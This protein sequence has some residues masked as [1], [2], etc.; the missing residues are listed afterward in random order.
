MPLSEGAHIRSR[1]SGG[2]FGPAIAS[3][4]DWRD[5]CCSRR[6][7]REAQVLRGQL[8]E[9]VGIELAATGY[10]ISASE[11]LPRIWEVRAVK[12][13]ARAHTLIATRVSGRATNASYFHRHLALSYF[14][15][16]IRLKAT[17]RNHDARYETQA[18]SG[19]GRSA[20]ARSRRSCDKSYMI[21]KLHCSTSD[22]M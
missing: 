11:A 4:G 17:K 12:G 2:G 9:L 13:R 14:D 10:V 1:T 5:C 19:V 16:T 7:W 22:R 15:N 6:D 21:G 18:E 8:H 20:A 3:R